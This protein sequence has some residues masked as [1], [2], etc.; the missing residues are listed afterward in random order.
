MPAR[1]AIASAGRR[2]RLLLAVGLTA[3]R[4]EFPR[5]HPTEGSMLAARQTA[6]ELLLAD[7]SAVTL[8]DLARHAEELEQRFH[9]H[10]QSDGIVFVPRREHPDDPEPTR[11]D[12]GADA[13]LFTGFAFATAVYRFTVTQSDL[14]LD[15][16]LREVRGL[17]LL[18]HVTGTPGVLVRCAI[19][20]E[21]RE[22][23]D[24]PERWR[25]RLWSDAAT[26]PGSR[27]GPYV[28]W[29]PDAMPDVLA[30][31]GLTLFGEVP[32]PTLPRHLFYARTTRD[33]LTGVLFGLAA[34]WS[35]LDPE[36]QGSTPD[37]RA[38]I[39]AARSIVG[40]IAR[41]LLDRLVSDAREQGPRASR[42]RPPDDAI[43]DLSLRMRDHRG[44]T[45]TLAND[46]SGKLEIALL[47]LNVAV[48]D[49]EIAGA[50]GPAQRSLAARR[51]ELRRAHDR[52]WNGFF[53]LNLDALTNGW[54]RS[55]FPWNLRCTQTFTLWLLER[56][57]GR[58]AELLDY[59]DGAEWK[60]VEDD[61]NT[62]F[63]FQHAVMH[64]G[65]PSPPDPAFTAALMNLKALALRPAR[66]FSSPL[67]GT[68]RDERPVPAHLR[69][70]ATEFLWQR[71]PS[72]V[73]GESGDPP[74]LTGLEESTGLS[75]LLPYWLGRA[76]GLLAAG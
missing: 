63:T 31:R 10:C 56:D 26:P 47:A 2:A 51:E 76:G 65:A 50:G 55:Y 5:Q 12:N 60:S 48:L 13:A 57:P 58:R 36:R 45:G 4:A 29:S 6:D 17:H 43:E 30:A 37:R 46:V 61:E 71:D 3:C 67:Y 24:Y 23:W 21:E 20:W 15:R 9:E 19:P 35:L 33:Q 54:A 68:K 18:T 52:V 75:F 69:K 34:G 8:R 28:D 42:R 64:G 25:G 59:A 7:P 1:P 22:R 27:P 74:D 44:G 32:P 39:A 62:W 14:D 49:E 73:G 38:R 11:F 72:S 66:S 40:E 16:V 41:D 53:Q 70:P